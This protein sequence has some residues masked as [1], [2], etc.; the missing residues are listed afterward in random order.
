M[1]RNIKLVLAYDGGN[2]H[3]FQRQNNAIAIQQIIEKNLE[4]LVTIMQNRNKTS[5]D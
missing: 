4:K 5:H 3:G 2:Y 1:M